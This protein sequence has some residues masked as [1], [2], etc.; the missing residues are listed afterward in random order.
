[1]VHS[2]WH[3]SPSLRHQILSQHPFPFPKTGSP[4]SSLQALGSGSPHSFSPAILSSAPTVITDGVPQGHLCVT[5]F[6]PAPTGPDL[7][8]ASVVSTSTRVLTGLCNHF[9]KLAVF[10]KAKQTPASDPAILLQR[11]YSTEKNVHANQKACTK[12]L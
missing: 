9:E 11:K 6:S 1:M 2:W 10:T 7:I 3:L 8:L 12:M 4:G 5:G